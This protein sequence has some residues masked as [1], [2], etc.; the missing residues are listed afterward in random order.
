MHVKF[1]TLF[2]FK[3]A[4]TKRN[5][6]TK[7]PRPFCTHNATGQSLGLR[8][9]YNKKKIEC[10]AFKLYNA[11]L[12]KMWPCEDDGYSEKMPRATYN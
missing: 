5:K 3:L 9:K 2:Q 10:D 8:A 7:Q 4:S 12:N 6:P 1:C 11:M